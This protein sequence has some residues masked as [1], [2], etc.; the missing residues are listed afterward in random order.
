MTRLVSIPKP[1]LERMPVYYRVLMHCREIGLQYISSK[2][3]GFRSGFDNAQVRKDLNHIW[4]GGRPGLGYEIEKLAECLADFLGLRNDTDAA[5]AGAGRLGSALVGYPGF[6]RYGFQIATVFDTDEN[7]IG[8]SLYGRPVMPL[9]KCGE[10]MERLGIKIGI[11][12]VPA[13][14][15]Q[16]VCGIMVKA[17]AKAIW[18]FAP[19]RLEVPEGVLVRDED[20]AVGLTTLAYHIKQQDVPGES[21]ASGSKGPTDTRRI[22]T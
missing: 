10:L 9:S 20:L 22:R 5:L 21:S 14:E 6:Q 8:K 16:D 15:A 12:T 1:T 13:A 2:D 17:G 11:I 3:L 4:S 7:K 18:N 19:V